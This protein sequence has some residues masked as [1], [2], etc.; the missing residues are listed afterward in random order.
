MPKNARAVRAVVPRMLTET[1][2]PNRARHA[3]DNPLRLERR[4]EEREPA[5]GRLAASYSNGRRCGITQ[6]EI[7][8]RSPSGM[9]ALSRSEIEEGMTVTICPEGST[10]PWMSGR[11][12]RSVKQRDGMWRVGLVF[13][14]RMAA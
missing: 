7:V 4:R 11:A 1:T 13:Q 8:D 2:R 6:L 14:R 3:G 9:G 10:I 5:T 12:A